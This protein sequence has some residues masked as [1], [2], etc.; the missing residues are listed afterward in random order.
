MIKFST[1]IKVISVLLL[2]YWFI[3]LCVSLLNKDIPSLVFCGAMFLFQWC[4]ILYYFLSDEI[5]SSK[6][7]I[8]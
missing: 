3:Q 8:K 5:N 6:V 4:T 2:A 7:F 1:L